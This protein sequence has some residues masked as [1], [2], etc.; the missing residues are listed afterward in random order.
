M[1]HDSVQ[2]LSCLGSCGL[3][4]LCLT[5]FEHWTFKFKVVVGGASGVFHL[6]AR[7]ESRE[8]SRGTASYTISPL[9]FIMMYIGTCTICA[10]LLYYR[11]DNFFVFHRNNATSSKYK[12]LT[13]IFR[14]SKD[15]WLYP[16]GNKYTFI[17]VSVHFGGGHATVCSFKC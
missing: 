3:L 11:L 12:R 7:L 13:V 6:F 17:V 2:L 1:R 15:R 10:K 8:L 4:Q 9:V 14:N 16:L 5:S